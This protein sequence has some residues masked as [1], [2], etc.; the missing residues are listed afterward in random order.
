MNFF[1]RVRSWLQS[2]IGLRAGLF[3]ES[4][5]SPIFRILLG[6]LVTLSACAPPPTPAV[7]TPLPPTASPTPN[8]PV[9]STPAFTATPTGPWTLVWEEEFE[10]PDGSPV[11]STRWSFDV[12]GHGWGNNELQYYTDRVD[13]A[14]LRG[15]S[16]VIRAQQETFQDRAY[17]SAR[18]VTKNKA[19]WLY[20]RFEAR[21][22][23][24]KGQ[25]IWPAIWMLPTDSV[26]GIWPLSGEIDIMELIGSDPW[27]VYGT[28]HWG[29][30]HQSNG[31]RYYLLGR[32]TF[33]DDFHVF[34]IEWEP[35]EIRWYVD[36][37]HHHTVTQWFTSSARDAFPAPFD[38]RFHI[39]LN[40]AVGG[41]WPGSPSASTVF[42][43]EMEV[44]YVRVYQRE[45]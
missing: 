40:V 26:Y 2:S 3:K 21:A 19:D 11:D 44:D 22:R 6:L 18:L 20:G 23:L 1:R 29:E 13:N 15:G 7:P 9:I 43:A 28:L 24:P 35:R 34:A 14:F 32:E 42:P 45:P 17:T 12:G 37:Y 10:G 27:T 41:N 31:D 4:P 5:V 16:L 33:N 30:P 25:G 8:L 39:L 38:Q 36:G